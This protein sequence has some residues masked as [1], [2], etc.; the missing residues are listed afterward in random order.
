MVPPLSW[1]DHVICWV[2]E[3]P[4]SEALTGD[5]TQALSF[6]CLKAVLIRAATLG[7]CDWIT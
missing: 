4:S 7:T 6:H 5:A 2:L 1:E 3:P